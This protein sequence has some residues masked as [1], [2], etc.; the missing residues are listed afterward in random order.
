[1]INGNPGHIP[2]LNILNYDWSSFLVTDMCSTSLSGWHQVDGLP[3]VSNTAAGIKYCRKRGFDSD[4]ELFM[5]RGGLKNTS[6]FLQTPIM[7][8]NPKTDP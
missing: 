8:Y 3:P 7:D 2:V 5:G 1:M 6:V 4:P